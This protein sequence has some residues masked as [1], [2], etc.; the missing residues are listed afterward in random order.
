M[1]PSRSAAVEAHAL[2]GWLVTSQ[3]QIAS[4]VAMPFHQKGM[5]LAAIDSSC[6]K[7][8]RSMAIL[9]LFAFDTA[10]C[11]KVHSGTELQDAKSKGTFF[12]FC[13][14]STCRTPLHISC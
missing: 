12:C 2:I 9:I 10:A 14:C 1:G 11:C 13:L 3:L 4:F 5:P 6:N 7:P 8:H